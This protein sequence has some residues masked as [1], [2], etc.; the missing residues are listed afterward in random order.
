MTEIDILYSR[1]R[2][3]QPQFG[4][5]E[6]LFKDEGFEEKVKRRIYSGGSGGENVAGPFG[7]A[8]IQVS[9]S[10]NYPTLLQDKYL[11]RLK[12]VQGGKGK[13]KNRLRVFWGSN[14]PIRNIL[15]WLKP[16]SFTYVL[17]D[18][19]KMAWVAQC[20]CSNQIIV[21][22][23][24][25][26]T[27]DQIIFV[28]MPRSGSE[29]GHH[30]VCPNGSYIRHMLCTELRSTAW[31]NSIVYLSFSSRKV[32]LSLLCGYIVTIGDDKKKD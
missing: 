18:S 27:F 12:Q 25:L 21:S 1:P 8:A 31:I 13:G 6:T 23:S 3:G 22:F 20:F 26:Y 11:T 30:Q 15:L 16:I 14:T 10:W 29:Y 9:R 4:L 7:K 28:C 24:L 19:K 5:F 32:H 2:E 17:Q